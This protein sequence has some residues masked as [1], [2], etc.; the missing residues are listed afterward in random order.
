MLAHGKL[1]SQHTQQKRQGPLQASGEGWGALLCLWVKAEGSEPSFAGVPGHGAAVGAAR[2]G[3]AT[4]EAV[5]ESR[6]ELA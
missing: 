3:S 5:R 4:Q 6:L 2:V 1:C